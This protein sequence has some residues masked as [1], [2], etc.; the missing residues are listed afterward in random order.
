[1]IVPDSAALELKIPPDS[2]WLTNKEAYT[3]SKVTIDQLDVTVYKSTDRVIHVYAE[4]DIPI[5]AARTEIPIDLISHSPRILALSW[6]DEA[7]C[8]HLDGALPIR[9]PWQASPL[10]PR[11]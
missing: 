7:I 6:G 2:D 3:L 10:P 11:L 9:L 4:A 8:L 5:R 1:M